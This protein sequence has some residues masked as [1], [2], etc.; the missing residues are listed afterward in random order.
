MNFPD[1]RNTW[2]D[3]NLWNRDGQTFQSFQKFQVFQW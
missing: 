2:N 1:Q 3:S